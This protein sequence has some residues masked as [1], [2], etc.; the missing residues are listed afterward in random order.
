[1]IKYKS[2]LAN[3]N[4]DALSPLPLPNS[5][6]SEVPIPSELVLSMEHMSTGPFTAAQTK[7]MMQRDPVLSRVLSYVLRSWPRLI[8]QSLLLSQTRVICL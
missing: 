7:S 6:T 1:M 8:T 4:A 2:G 3:S 5:L